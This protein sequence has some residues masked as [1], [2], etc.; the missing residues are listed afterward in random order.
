MTRRISKLSLLSLLTLLLAG[1]I[2]SQVIN[3]VEIKG[4]KQFSNSDYK[5]WLNID[6]GSNYFPSIRDTIKSRI[7]NSL[8]KRGYFH[9]NVDTV[10]AEV[11]NDSSTAEISISIDE[12]EPTY[13]RGIT[14]DK[15]NYEDS[16]KIK[17]F[18]EYL[19]GSVF[20]RSDL[21]G[22][23]AE[24]LDYLE[25]SGYPF[26]SVEIVSVDFIE[27]TEEGNY[28]AINLAVDKG[29]KSTID[30]I[31]IE[32]NTKTKDYVIIRNARIDKSE[33]YSQELIEEIPKRLNRLRFFEQ[34]EKP[35]FYFNS[36][37]E[38]V[39]R[40][41]V[42]EKQTNSF[43]G[44][45][46]Y[47]PGQD[48]GE[49]GY[50][51]GFVNIGLR[52]IFGTGRA[53]SFEW[54]QEN[55]LSQRLH[56]K[57]MEPWIFGFPF[58]I[59]GALFQRKQD[60][61]YVQRRLDGEIKYIATENISASVLIESE[62]TIPNQ[63]DADRL[64]VYNSNILTTGVGLSINT[65]D[66]FYAPTEGLIFSNTYKFSRKEITGPEKFLTSDLET[67]LELQRIEVDFSYFQQF[68]SR[69]VVALG[70]HIREMKGPYFEI[71]DLY[72]LGGTNTLRGYR[73]NQFLGNRIFWSNLEYRYS[74]DKRSFGF[75]FYD[76]GYY[77]RDAD[78]ERDITKFESFKTS[79]GIGLSLETG[80]GVLQVS[81][82]LA[83]GDSFGDGKIHFGLLNEF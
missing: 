74:L 48:E 54:E 33:P 68:W 58:N 22:S 8:S 72:R 17:S 47:V 69:Q 62:T 32:G 52:N 3:S 64:T 51:T 75:V 35:Q 21:K 29:E 26:A 46:G 49:S 83:Q 36:K 40:I 80:L 66:D 14:F 39:L 10:I 60:T 81:Y 65:T 43:D 42:K 57:Y 77:L 56:L 13:I 76:T 63:S 6:S 30:K 12:N 70:I 31:E 18:Y 19:I 16:S 11:K 7:A 27:N 24:T 20:I 1:T 15:L 73:E 44:I 82:A 5:G 34:V 41:K 50:L 37:N 2:Q 78:K 59:S 79:Y 67:N 71:S 61:T 28:A 53:A 38:G 4:N 25:N 45:I 9:F 23:I 55:R